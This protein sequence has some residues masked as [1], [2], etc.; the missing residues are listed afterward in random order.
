MSFLVFLN[1]IYMATCKNPLVF[2]GVILPMRRGGESLK[3][4]EKHKIVTTEL[5]VRFFAIKTNVF[6]RGLST[7]AS[8]INCF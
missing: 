6:S 4:D 5:G 3:F 2:W 8:K 1:I 7:F